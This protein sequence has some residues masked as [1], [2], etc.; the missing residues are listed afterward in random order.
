MKDQAMYDE[1]V[2]SYGEKA[3]YSELESFLKK[4]KTEGAEI[5][6]SEELGMPARAVNVFPPIRWKK[7]HLDLLEALW[8]AMSKR[9]R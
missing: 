5:D 3:F 6:F 1:I 2:K 4:H 9:G 8:D 7:E